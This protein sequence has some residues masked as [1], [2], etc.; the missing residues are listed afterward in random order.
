MWSLPL[1][2]FAEHA[3]VQRLKNGVKR[4]V[5]LALPILIFSALEESVKLVSGKPTTRKKSLINIIL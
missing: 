2:S 3:E 5:V 4:S 1:E